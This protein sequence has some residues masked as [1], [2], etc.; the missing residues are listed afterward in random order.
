MADPGGGLGIQSLWILQYNLVWLILKVSVKSVCYLQ[1]NYGN[2]FGLK[3]EKKKNTS[4]KLPLPSGMALLSLLKKKRKFSKAIVFERRTEWRSLT[5]PNPPEQSEHAD[6]GAVW[7][8]SCGLW[9]WPLFREQVARGAA[10][11][12][13][14][15]IIIEEKR[16]T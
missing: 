11:R 5:I 1:C 15:V 13:N 2:T 3:K 4:W 12:N 10:L 14:S 16:L 7:G 6:P 9:M 8:R